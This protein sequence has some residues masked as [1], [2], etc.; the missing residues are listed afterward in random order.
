MSYGCV[1]NSNRR[2]SKKPEPIVE[3]QRHNFSE[4]QVKEFR[5]A[6]DQFDIDK[7]GS[8]SADELGA[9]LKEVDQEV[10]PEELQHMINDVDFDGSGEID[11]DEFLIMMTRKGKKDE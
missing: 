1:L 6:F 3:R 7:G 5:E 8:I 2:P 4:A 9:C 11:F 10:S